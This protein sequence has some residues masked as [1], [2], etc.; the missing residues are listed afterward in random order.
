MVVP[1]KDLRDFY[2]CQ[3]VSFIVSH[4]NVKHTVI[5]IGD[6]EH[7]SLIVLFDHVHFQVVPFELVGAH[8][9]VGLQAVLMELEKT[10]LSLMVVGENSHAILRVIGDDAL[11]DV[12]LLRIDEAAFG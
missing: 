5:L 11:D 12:E 10:V 4:L 2:K 9:L 7:V 3:I 6:G 1:P 8:L